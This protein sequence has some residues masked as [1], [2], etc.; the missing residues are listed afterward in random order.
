[1]SFEHSIAHIKWCLPTISL[2]QSLIFSSQAPRKTDMHER[3][4][5]KLNRIAEIRA[6][7]AWRREK[8]D[9]ALDSKRNK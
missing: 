6:S 2:I 8:I 3:L 4:R 9:G 7:T 1:M 5:F